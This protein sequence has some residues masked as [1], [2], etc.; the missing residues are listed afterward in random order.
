MLAVAHKALLC[1]ALFTPHEQVLLLVPGPQ[2]RGCSLETPHTPALCVM[3]RC[4]SL[5]PRNEL[6]VNGSHLCLFSVFL[7]SLLDWSS[8]CMRAGSFCPVS[9]IRLCLAHSKC[10]GNICLHGVVH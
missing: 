9:S 3:G 2:R 7:V 6:S 10:S 1:P 5:L 8:G 4:A